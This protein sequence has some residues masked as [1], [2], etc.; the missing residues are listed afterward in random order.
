MAKKT[1]NFADLT[2]SKEEAEQR[3]KSLGMET[4][5]VEQKPEK[6]KGEGSTT[7]KPKTPAIKKVVPARPA[8]ASPAPAT[9]TIKIPAKYKNVPHEFI[10]FSYIVR[11]EYHETMRAMGKEFGVSVRDIM[12]EALEKTIGQFV[13]KYKPAPDRE[14]E[15]ESKKEK[16][17]KLF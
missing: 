9:L 11:E 4:G 12:D 5:V 16:L 17:K 15:K 3:L 10:R 14:K 8:D 2:I 13:G 7:K 1:F 6:I